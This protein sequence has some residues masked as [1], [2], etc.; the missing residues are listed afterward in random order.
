MV[1][2]PASV[3]TAAA[4]HRYFARRRHNGH[5]TLG[6][7]TGLLVVGGIT[8]AI[9]ANSSGYGA[10]GPFL[11]GALGTVASVP[12]LIRGIVLTAAHAKGREE[13]VLQAWQQHRLP[14]R[15]ARRALV[16]EYTQP[17]M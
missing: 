8:V 13:R 3:D 1:A 12:I 7:G 2:A 14:K 4:L 10:L 11:L 5:V 15:W 17:Q 6:V 9:T 16:P